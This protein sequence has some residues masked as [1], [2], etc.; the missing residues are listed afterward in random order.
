V[1][2]GGG[3][4]WW[5]GGRGRGGGGGGWEC[6]PSGSPGPGRAA[7]P[8]QSH[9]SALRRSCDPFL[10][11][12][13]PGAA[14]GLVRPSQLCREREWR[15]THRAGSCCAASSKARR[16]PSPTRVD[17]VHM[18]RPRGLAPRCERAFASPPFPLFVSLFHTDAL[19]RHSAAVS[20]PPELARNPIEGFSAGL[21]DDCNGVCP[22]LPRKRVEASPPPRA[23]SF[24]TPP[25]GPA[26]LGAV[27]E[28][29]ITII[30]PPDTL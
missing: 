13:T 24:D 7:P 19:T 15:W 27:Y 10:C 23:P 4:G 9:R 14:C 2:V 18:L 11:V 21:V 5:W 8:W 29:A 16:G 30:G 20:R 17:T 12:I 26:V 6:C 1:W 28:W 25:Y 3:G 22:S